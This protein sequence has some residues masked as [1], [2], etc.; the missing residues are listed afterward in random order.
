MNRTSKIVSTVVVIIVALA[1]FVPIA[2]IASDAG[3]TVGVLGIIIV[4]GAWAG[5][6]AIWKKKGD[7]GGAIHG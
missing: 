5:I 1:L 3:E 6:K 7:D 4:A 2:G